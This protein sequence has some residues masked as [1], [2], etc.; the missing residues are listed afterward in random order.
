MLYLLKAFN[1]LATYI[2]SE[3]FLF[4]YVCCFSL[5]LLLFV[6]FKLICCISW[7]HT[8]L[9]PWCYI[10]KKSNITCSAS[11]EFE[12]FCTSRVWMSY[13]PALIMNC[14]SG[15]KCFII[16]VMT[17]HLMLLLLWSQNVYDN[18]WSIITLE[19]MTSEIKFIASRFG[20]GNVWQFH[21]YNVRF[22]YRLLKFFPKLIIIC[23]I[24]N[25]CWLK[26]FCCYVCVSYFIELK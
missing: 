7:I 2:C 12:N 21:F 5:L 17:Y 23:G 25:I 8:C 10:S 22:L 6:I 9:L 11:T 3:L 14:W 18:T 15:L 19:L 24:C 1:C 26:W 20:E 16:M 13:F 4:C